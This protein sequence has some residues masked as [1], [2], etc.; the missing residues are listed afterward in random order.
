MKRT[1]L[2][3]ALALA[4]MLTFSETASAHWR[5]YGPWYGGYPYAVSTGGPYR[6][7]AGPVPYS[8]LLVPDAPSTVV[9][10]PLGRVHYARPYVAAYP[11]Y[12]SY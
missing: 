2:A 11:T 8:T 12:W 3:A 5:H 6:T 10:G 4:A 1:I 9:V 7:V